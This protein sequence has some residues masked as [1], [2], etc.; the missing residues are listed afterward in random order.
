MKTNI[1]KSFNLSVQNNKIGLILVCLAI[2]FVFNLVIFWDH[3]FNEIGFPMDFSKRYYASPAFFTTLISQGEFPQWNP[4]QSMGYPQFMN[5]QSGIFYPF[6]WLYPILEI[7]YTL[8]SAV[9]LQ[10]LHI[11]AGSVGLF[12][13]LQ[14]MFKSYRYAL[15]GAIA[16]Q[17]FGGFFSQ[18]PYPDMIRAFAIVPWLFYVFTLNVE[19]PTLSR[20]VLFIPIVIFVLATGA[21]PGHF[22]SSI[23]MISFFIIFQTLN[24]FGCIRKRKSILILV[25]LFSLMVLG[26]GVSVIH[27]GA[28]IQFG[29]ELTRFDE[30][31]RERNRFPLTPDHFFHLFLPQHK[32]ES[33]R[34]AVG[35]YLGLP[36]LIF[37]SFTPLH[38]LKKYWVFSGMIILAVLMA[39][40]SN[41]FFYQIMTSFVRLLGLSRFPSSEYSIFFVIP[42]IIFSIIG[43]KAILQR[44]F[45]WRT[46]LIRIAIIITWFSYGVFTLYS[47]STQMKWQSLDVLNQQVVLSVIFL[48]ITISALTF[49]SF[50]SKF[51]NF[52]NV[53][54]PI[55]LSL[56]VM[57][58][59]VGIISAEGFIIISENPRWK[60]D[61]LDA[62]YIEFDFQLEENGKL[63][64]YGIL[65]N[66]PDKR[67]NREL[68]KKAE[69]IQWKGIIDGS[70]MMRNK[71]DVILKS[72]DIAIKEPYRQFMF[73][74]WAPLLLDLAIE[75]SQTK[76]SLPETTFENLKHS[77]IQSSVIQTHYGINS[78]N[79]QVSLDEPKLMI[80]N[81]IYFP[82]W[83]ATLIYP[84]K[85]VQLQAIEVND[86][87][88]AWYL[89]AG[90]YEMTANFQFPNFVTYQIISLSAFAIWIVI[91]V[92]FWRKPF[93]LT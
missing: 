68:T 80:E 5:P 55:V 27:L 63:K 44:K 65:E 60:I 19:K 1:L 54:K 83:T 35:L 70:Y 85:E 22:I 66:L 32:P 93:L 61:P 7:P 21:Y 46:F 28:I 2:L 40:G 51:H 57:I 92:V 20:R 31:E 43:L 82:G 10:T 12:F 38:S 75:N 87:F 56:A 45:T 9:V 37:A 74:E 89:P 14:S 4:F 6:F 25:V 23:F 58:F 41:S 24:G 77:P 42:I 84:D 11:F 39:G 16:F 18:A 47:A 88:R 53:R 49:L 30:D 67:P 3:Y 72:R 48:I 81:E 50:K 71:G 34:Y 33:E 62:K 26:F 78:I 52:S 79:Y 8:Q 59:F 76:I 90:D 91:V 36:I 15:L 69:G 64:T 73:K 29:D 13:F 86:V 17:F